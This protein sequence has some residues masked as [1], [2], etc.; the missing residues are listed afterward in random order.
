VK[1]T[2]SNQTLF[3]A[4]ERADAD[5]PSTGSPASGISIGAGHAVLERVTIVSARPDGVVYVRADYQ[6]SA[7]AFDS[8]VVA[9]VPKRPDAPVPAES[10]PPTALE[11]AS[12]SGELVVLQPPANAGRT[13][14]LTSYL[15]PT[16]QYA[17]TQ[18]L[19]DTGRRPSR[20]DVH[21]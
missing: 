10:D 11:A 7:E 6:R 21:A 17:L 20:I 15:K 13:G 19:T 16:E 8:S 18:R 2:A 1:V 5:A 3:L 14:G 9:T 4:R 12:G